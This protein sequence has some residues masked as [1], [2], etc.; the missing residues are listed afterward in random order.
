MEIVVIKSEDAKLFGHLDPYGLIDRIGFP[1]AFGLGVIMPGTKSD[2]VAGLLVATIEGGYIVGKD[3]QGN[4]VKIADGQQYLLVN[5][6][7]GQKF[8][9]TKDTKILDTDNVLFGSD[10]ELPPHELFSRTGCERYTECFYKDADGN[11]KSIFVYNEE[12]TSDPALC[13]SI[14]SM[15]VNKDVVEDSS[16]IPHIMKNGNIAYSMADQIYNLWEDRNFTL[17]PNDTT[18]CSYS[19]FYAKMVGQIAT[20]GSVFKTTSESL[21]GTVDSV[22]SSRQAVI[23]VSSDEELTNMIKFQNAYNAASRY[24]NTVSQMIDYL[25]NSL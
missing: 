10:M 11:A 17:N 13:Y 23:G 2:I 8:F 1:G 19:E 4:E 6:S 15:T 9:I 5:D 14:K 24:I 16:C 20:D 3:I 25:L 21:K 7:A 12:D 22:E 18:P